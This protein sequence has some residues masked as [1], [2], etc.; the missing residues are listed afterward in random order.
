MCRYNHT[1]ENMN[2]LS[3]NNPVFLEPGKQHNRI[4]V[5]KRCNAVNEGKKTAKRYNFAKQHRYE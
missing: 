3:Q 4:K 5:V 1:I 2:E